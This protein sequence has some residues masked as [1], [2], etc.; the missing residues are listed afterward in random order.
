[1]AREDRKGRRKQRADIQRRAPELGHYFVMTDT[2]ETEKNYLMGLQES[3]NAD[4]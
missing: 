4:L 1:M 2:D 3:L